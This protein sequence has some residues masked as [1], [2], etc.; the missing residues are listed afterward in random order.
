MK[1]ETTIF[2]KLKSKIMEIDLKNIPTLFQNNDT[3]ISMIHFGKEIL[4]KK[5]QIKTNSMLT[6]CYCQILKK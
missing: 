4:N 3:I 2:D 1:K 5:E 6:P